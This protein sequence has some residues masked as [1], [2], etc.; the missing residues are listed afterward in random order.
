MEKTAVE[1]IV[2]RVPEYDL[3]QLRVTEI[4]VNEAYNGALKI[5]EAY[6]VGME[7]AKELTLKVAVY[8]LYLRATSATP[9]HIEKDYAQTLKIL[10]DLKNSAKIESGKSFA[11]H[12]V[13]A[14]KENT[15]GY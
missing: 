5:V 9:E 6:G 1:L 3:K 10:N 12:S 7:A 8:N 11:M 13:S 15:E 4:E 14:K 2:A